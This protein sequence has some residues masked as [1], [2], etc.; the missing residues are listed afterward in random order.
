MVKY[1]FNSLDDFLHSYPLSIDGIL[2]DGGGAIFPVKGI[3]LN[4]TILFADITSFSARTLELNPVETLIF[5]NNFF[6]WMSASAL[7][8]SNGIIDKYIGDELM[9][10][11]AN[12]LGSQDHF[13]DAVKVAG[14]MID[15]DSLD[16]HPHIG[17]ASGDVI[18]GY[19]GTPLKYNCSVFG[20]PVAMA[21]RCTSIKTEHINSIIFPSSNWKTGYKLDE[22]LP[23]L[24]YKDR[25]F[26][27]HIQPQHW[28]LNEPRTEK[29]KN[30]PDT[31]ILELSTNRT[32]LSTQSMTERAKKCFKGL[33]DSGFYRKVT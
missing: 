22:I 13:V 8:D 19:T 10:V 3:E 1:K 2:N 18:I 25:I 5:V 31:E 33:N 30:M 23:P 24:V 9:V 26:G 32:H 28:K 12:E 20:S 17:I 14:R 6:A 29:L 4:A 11:F 27:D 16:F 15:S 7:K 21:A